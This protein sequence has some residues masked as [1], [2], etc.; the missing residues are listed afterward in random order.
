MCFVSVI[1]VRMSK[2]LR[3]NLIQVLKFHDFIDTTHSTTK[4]RCIKLELEDFPV[5]SY[6]S[7]Q[8]PE[9]LS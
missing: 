8:T 7:H 2:P 5:T 9:I 6:A 3:E 1:Q 4:H